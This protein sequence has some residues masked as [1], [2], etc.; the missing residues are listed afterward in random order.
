MRTSCGCVLGI[1]LVFGAAVLR[2]DVRAQSVEAH[3]AAGSKP[4]TQK[5]AAETFKNLQ[6]LGDLKGSPAPELWDTM[7]VMAGS[8]SVSCNYCHVAEAGPY[9]SDSNKTKLIAR[10]MISMTRAIN[11]TNFGG[12]RVVTCNTCHQGSP[13]PK[14][15]PSPWNRTAEQIV[16]YSQSVGAAS[17]EKAAPGGAA[18]QTAT[19]PDVSQIMA[20]YRRAV[21]AKTLTSVRMS[22]TAADLN[23]G[24]RPREVYVIFP[25]KIVIA[26]GG[27]QQIVNGDRGWQLTPQLRTQLQPGTIAAVK[28][29]AASLLPVKYEKSD[30]TRRVIGIETIGDRAYYLVES[31]P[32]RLRPAEPKNSYPDAIERMFFDVQTGLLYKVQ[33]T[34][35]TT[36]GTKVEETSFED[37][38][39][40]S[41]LTLPFLI[42]THFMED[43][44][45]FKIS[46]IQVNI[47]VDPTKFEPTDPKE[48][49]SRSGA[50]PRATPFGG[51][52]ASPQLG[53]ASGLAATAGTHDTGRGR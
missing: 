42:V 18:T 10:S 38:R 48:A 12:R 28:N 50:R 51:A 15:T 45:L 30:V 13:H 47:D 26:S 27:T 35:E 24:P 46:E 23:R 2:L 43:E 32:G 52:A 37:Y 22:G 16:A 19:L 1:A 36:L 25:D 31:H 41:G 17:I 20:N 44:N 29:F 6:V 39:Q 34:I 5:T 53:A 8:L 14:S 33:T 4:A 11:Q 3:Q 40:V 7:Q 49:A 9:D 21:G